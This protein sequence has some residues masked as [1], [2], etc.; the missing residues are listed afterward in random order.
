MASITRR[1]DSYLIKVSMGYDS[2][3]KQIIKSKTW[4]I[5]EGTNEERARKKAEKEAVLFEE[6]CKHGEVSNAP[7][8][9][10][11]DF[12]PTYLETI[13]SSIEVT[14]L[15]Y[16]T[17]AIENYILPFMGD[18]IMADI[19]PSNIQNFISHMSKKPSG[20]HAKKDDTFSGDRK[21]ISP[22]TVMR[23][24][25]I[26]RSIFRIAYK[27]EI[28]QVNPT[29]ARRLEI[30]KVPEP[31]IEFFDPDQAN[32]ISEYLEK[33]PLQ[34]KV[35]ILLCIII[36][37]RRGEIVGLKFSD[38]NYETKIL[39][40][41]RT[42]YKLKG[43]PVGLKSP[44][45]KKVNYIAVND[46]VLALVDQ[47]KEDKKKLKEKLGDRWAG[48]EWLFTQWDGSIMNP[49]TMTRT[50]SKFLAKNNIEHKKL[51]AMRHS[52]ATIMLV[53]G[54]SIKD[55]QQRLGH[56]DIKTTNKYLHVL[57]D[58]DA[59]ATNIMTDIVTGAYKNKDKKE[60]E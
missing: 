33:E 42:A 43:K 47:L 44:K 28:V 55:V 50:F 57:A 38:F 13:S 19:K 12:I 10:L 14:T 52:A 9:R 35:Y 3:G 21:P 37:A 18:W 17:R 26:V 16:Y 24:L 23:Y 29:D 25:T 60:S 5:P 41:E 36:G 32:Q 58:A 31:K 20:V 46:Y 39:T 27:L 51:H 30:P 8:L 54:M 49:H 4:N 7:K 40:I 1:G 11:R 6:K 59:K 22:A 56:A 48:D 2:N 34:D 45:G 15:E 53:S